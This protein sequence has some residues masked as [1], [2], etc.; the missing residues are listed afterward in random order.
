MSI[1]QEKFTCT[2]QLSGPIETAWKN[3]TEADYLETWLGRGTLGP[4]GSTYEIVQTEKAP[5]PMPGKVIG[6]ILESNPPHFVRFTWQHVADGSEYDPN[7]DTEVEFRLTETTDGVNFTITHS[8]LRVEDMG[9][10]KPGWMSHT[11][12]LIDQLTGRPRGDFKERFEEYCE[13]PLPWEAVKK[14]HPDFVGE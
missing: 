4:T 14:R 13:V 5:F 10:V 11:D 7:M 3:I 1:A 6:E 9:L 8:K 2:R 12:F